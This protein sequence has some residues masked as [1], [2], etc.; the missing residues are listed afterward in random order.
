MRS[1][2]I[3]YKC[4]PIPI[5]KLDTWPL[6]VGDVTEKRISVYRF[7]WWP[8]WRYSPPMVNGHY[9]TS[10][11]SDFFFFF[12][13]KWNFR[14]EMYVL[15]FLLWL[16]RLMIL[17]LYLVIWSKPRCTMS[18]FKWTTLGYFKIEKITAF[19]ID[20][21]QDHLVNIFSLF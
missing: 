7:G 14:I 21:R 11:Y 4:H 17:H 8:M 10:L 6:S 2:S 16:G 13:T 5:W 12:K 9:L 20:L 19:W 1:C 3:T 15:G 18:H